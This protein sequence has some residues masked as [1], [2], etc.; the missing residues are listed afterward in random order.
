MEKSKYILGLLLLLSACQKP[1][2]SAEELATYEREVNLWHEQRLIDVKAPN[3]WLNLAGLYWLEGGINTFGSNQ[4]NTII[5]PAGKIAEHAGH[6]LVTGKRV[7]LFAKKEAAITYLGKPINELEVFNSD[8]AKGME[9]KSGTLRWT[10]I[11]R[12]DKL[13]I[14][15][16]DDSSEVAKKFVG[17]ERFA[18]SPSYRIEAHFEKAD[19]LHTVAITNVV[20]QTTE[21]PSPGKLFFKV[22]GKKLSLDVLK[23]ETEY[24]IIFADS[25]TGQETYGGGRFLY[26]KKQDKKNTV[27]LDFNKAYNPPCVIT[28]FATCPLPPKQNHL[29]VAIRAGEKKYGTHHL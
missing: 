18:I 21:V 26:V 12:G 19:S 27:I 23:A 22:R 10:I 6:F 7:K 15:L 9:V 8:S 25:T 16:R 29:S 4:R 11:Q 2:L 1:V 17:I 28:P 20:G 3:G 5:F 24:F 14:R 13:G